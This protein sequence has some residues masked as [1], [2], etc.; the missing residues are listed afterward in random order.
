LAIRRLAVLFVIILEGGFLCSASQLPCASAAQYRALL[1]QVEQQSENP[2]VSL[3]G[4]A[5]AIPAQC[6]FADRG[7]SFHLSNFEL[8]RDL[9]QIGAKPEERSARLK[10]FQENLRQRIGGMDAYER[11][12]DATAKP[13]LQG[14]MQRREFRQVGRQDA[15][16]L[17]QEWAYRLLRKLLSRILKDPSQVVLGSKI[18]AWTLCILVGGFLLWKLYQWAIQERPPEAV[19]EVIPFAPSSKGWREWL[20][21]AQAAV[22]QG[23]LREAVHAAYW[24]AISH[25]ESSGAWRPD[26]ARTPREYLRLMKQSDP[27]HPLLADI[28]HDFEVVWYGNRPPALTEWESFLDKVER[29]GCR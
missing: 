12:V 27:A 20:R 14:I 7:Q 16:A 23:E 4:L 9:R 26:R 3:A 11:G 13:K 10:L 18:V 24:A 28:T 29:L 5:D 19:R 21:E 17:L 15:S 8:R 2:D 25:L 6:D 1:V 22:A